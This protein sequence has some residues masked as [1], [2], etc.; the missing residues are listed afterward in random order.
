MAI[1][2]S[3]AARRLGMSRSTVSR[4]LGS[5]ASQEARRFGAGGPRVPN[6]ESMLKIAEVLRWPVK[7]QVEAA[8]AGRYPEEL[9]AKLAKT[10]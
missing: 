7:Q 4:Y 1:T 6:R 5:R 9:A 10:N 2:P 8:A 3:E